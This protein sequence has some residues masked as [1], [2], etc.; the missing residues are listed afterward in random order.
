MLW[1]LQAVVTGLIGVPLGFLG[2]YLA[3]KRY[4]KP[5]V[6]LD[7]SEVLLDEVT[8]NVEFQ[9]KI[10]M[11]GGLLGQGV[12]Q[13][14]GI[15]KTGGKFKIED[16]IAQIIAGFAQRMIVGGANQQSGMETAPQD[17]LGSSFK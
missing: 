17:K 7:F 12:R 6:I 11:M 13:G 15:G 10:Y 8:Q 4:V 16:A 14:I 1:L 3:L 2:A 9:K 5:E